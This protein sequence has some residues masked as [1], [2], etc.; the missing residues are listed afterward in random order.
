MP[1]AEK[2]DSITC[3]VN[4]CAKV[5]LITFNLIF[6][7]LLDMKDNLNESLKTDY[8]KKTHVTAAF[9]WA[10]AKMLCCGVSGPADYAESVW[11]AESMGRG[12]NVSKTCCR[13]REEAD[14]HKNPKPLNETLCQNGDDRHSRGC[15]AGLEE[16]VKRE[17]TLLVTVACG[18]AALQ[19]STQRSA[20]RS[21]MMLSYA[22]LVGIILSICLCKEL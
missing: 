1:R 2:N 14:A 13:L 11:K 20:S 21:A 19:V 17:G 9:D 3:G 6:W 5:L 8:G 18:V 22:Q 10:Q 4:K 7:I 15:L 12:D 16:V